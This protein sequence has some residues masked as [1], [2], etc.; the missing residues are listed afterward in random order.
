MTANFDVRRFKGTKSL[1][2][3][4]TSW[5][6][7]KNNFLGYSYIVVGVLCMLLSALFGAKHMIN[8]RK[9]GDTRY[10]VWKEA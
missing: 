10:L 6:G 3:S 8:P 9:L 2:I 5:F 7:G 1:V 4:T